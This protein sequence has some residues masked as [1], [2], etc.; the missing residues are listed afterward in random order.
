MRSLFH[1]GRT[2]PVD[3]LLAA[4]SPVP[5]QSAA[6]PDRETF[7][8][9]A[10]KRLASNDLLQS[11]YAYRERVTDVRMNPFGRMGTGPIEVY[12]VYPVAGQDADLRRLIERDGVSVPPAGA[13]R[14]RS[15][16]PRAVSGVAPGR[17]GRGA[18]RA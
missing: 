11:G 17:G 12:D 6:L 18:K 9:E 4:S 2:R 16:V 7:L 15:R 8:A 14:R 5:A 3:L 10:R 1:E 13:D